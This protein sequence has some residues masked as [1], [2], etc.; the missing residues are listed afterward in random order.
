[1]NDKLKLMEE[2]LKQEKIS[3]IKY[4]DIIDNETI[5]KLKEMMK[6]YNKTKVKSCFESCKTDGQ[7]FTIEYLCSI[8]NEKQIKQVSK[9]MLFE[10]LEDKC[11]LYCDKCDKELE[12][13]KKELEEKEKERW[14]E[15]NKQ[16][17]NDYYNGWLNCNYELNDEAKNR[18]YNVKNEVINILQLINKKDLKN[19]VDNQMTYKEYLST[20]YWKL[21]SMLAK[22]KAGYKC[23]LCGSDYNL[24]VH[25]RTYEHKGTEI[26]NMNDLIVLCQE[27]HSKFHG[28][29]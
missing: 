20:P 21:V 2:Y 14:E 18:L 3:Y 12:K 16:I 7:L 9:R 11:P 8:C 24:N 5:I 28:V 17:I 29:V 19:Y 10:I 26:L 15:Y 6:K 13:S 4:E 1:M 25:H 22:K 23:Q 27:C